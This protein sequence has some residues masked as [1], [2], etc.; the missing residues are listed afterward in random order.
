MQA[1]DEFN[2]TVEDN[3]AVTLT[4]V[5]EDTDGDGFRDSL[6]A[7]S[8]SDLNDPN[9]TPLQQ[10]LVAWY[11]FDGNASDMSGN[12][13]DLS[14]SG[15]SF[16]EDRHGVSGKSC[17]LNQVYLSDTNAS[18]SID[19]N[20]SFSYSLWVQSIWSHPHIL[21][22]LDLVILLAIGIL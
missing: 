3:F 17:R 8:G 21:K 9:S 2:A 20:A 11:P 12:G 10:G 6:E 22:L 5:Y 7:S 1:K 13:N 19:D 15:H 14:G 4:D 18:F 16:G